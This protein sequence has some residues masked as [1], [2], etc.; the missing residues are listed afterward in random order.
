MASAWTPAPLFVERG[1]GLLRSLA[2]LKGSDFP[3]ANFLGW[4]PCRLC[5]GQ[6]HLPTGLS[7][8]DVLSFC[9]AC[10]LLLPTSTVRRLGEEQ[11]SS[12]PPRKQG[13]SG[14]WPVPYVN[15]SRY[16]VLWGLEAG[17]RWLWEVT[18]Y[19]GGSPRGH[20]HYISYSS[21]N[22]SSSHSAPLSLCWVAVAPHFLRAAICVRLLRK[23][24][25]R[26][27]FEQ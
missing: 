22:F 15:T 9:L 25:M 10:L 2:S 23:L 1:L 3:V 26:Q 24:Y 7:R 11:G 20:E 12:L 13:C 27:P 8:R 21:P 17:P 4:L 18:D 19:H 5:F 14:P 6:Y 16:W